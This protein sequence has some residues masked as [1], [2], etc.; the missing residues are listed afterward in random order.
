MGIY[1]QDFY[2]HNKLE[3]SKWIILLLVFG[4]CLKI[5]G[6]NT[7]QSKLVSIPPTPQASSL[8]KFLE[9]PVSENTGIPNITVPLYSIEFKNCSFP[10]TLKYHSSGLKVE[11]QSGNIGLG[12]ALEAGGTISSTVYDLPDF[13]V[14]S[15]YGTFPQNR[16]MNPQK[17][18]TG[19]GVYEE[20]ADYTQMMSLMGNPINHGASTSQG[21]KSDLQPDIFYYS[22]FDR[23]GKF[24]F[25]QNGTARPMPHNGLLIEKTS[26]GYRIK[27]EKG[28]VYLYEEPENIY[29]SST[30]YSNHQE[31]G[32]GSTSSL[33]VSYHL[34]NITTPLNEVINISYIT[35]NYSYANVP[36]YTRYRTLPGQQNCVGIEGE[37]RTETTTQITGKFINEITSNKGHRIKFVYSDCQRLDMPGTYALKQLEVYI[38]GV[39]NTIELIHGYFGLDSYDCNTQI[40]PLSVRLQLKKIKEQPK[41]DYSFDYFGG[42][43]GFPNRFSTQSD[44]WGYYNGTGSTFP[45]DQEFGFTIGGDKSPSL[46]NTRK[47]ILEKITYPTGGTT[48]FEH[49]LNQYLDTVATGTSTVQNGSG[50]YFEEYSPQPVSRT[51]NFTIPLNVNPNSIYVTYNC[52]DGTYDPQFSVLLHNGNNQYS[53]AFS[54]TGSTPEY[55]TLSPGNYAI[56]LYQSG[57]FEEGN[58]RIFWTETVGANPVVMN[59]NAGGLR[60]KTI[61]DYDALSIQPAHI[62]RY[63]YNQSANAAYSSGKV[64]NKPLYRYIYN[65]HSYT[66]NSDNT[67]LL[68]ETTCSYYLQTSKS[69]LPLTGLQ[70]NNTIYTE[71]QKYTEGPDNN[72]YT[73]NTYSFAYDLKPYNGYPFTPPTSYE[74]MSGYLLKSETFKKIPGSYC[75]IKRL[76]N[77]YNF[78]YTPPDIYQNYQ[79]SGAHYTLPIKP[80]EY[81]ALGLNIIVDRP[82]YVLNSAGGSRVYPARFIIQSFKLISSWVY[83]QN[84]TEELFE[85]C[86]SPILNSTLN[87]YDN[88]I[89]A[90]LSRT[91][92][93]SSNG[94][95]S[96]K[97]FTYAHDYPSVGNFIDDMKANNLVTLPI[98]RVSYEINAENQFSILSGE[99]VEYKLGGKGLIDNLYSL[100]TDKKINLPDFK[101]SNAP[102][103][104]LPSVSNPAS[105]LKDS[106]YVHKTNIFRYDDKGNVLQLSANAFPHRSYLY[107]YNKHYPVA[108]IKNADYA[109]I[110]GIL[111]VSAIENFG[112][113]LNPDKAAVDAF[114]APLKANLPNAFITSY[115]YKPLVGMT[116]QTDAKGMTTYY[117]YDAFGRLQYV[118]D[119]NQNIVKSNNYHYK[120]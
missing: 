76:T 113:Q 19:T 37:S 93:T 51:V 72:G 20:N 27:D 56:D 15:P 31:M 12:W 106:R 28:V 3:I 105:F 101:F 6:Q 83:L 16:E 74:W 67:S 41:G 18:L 114:L 107:S 80:N 34:T 47:G 102:N 58:F 4:N 69:K 63:T 38:N 64:F 98:E 118:K 55:I 84:N 11:E 7:P 87:Y 104:T 66:I 92:S 103:G 78:N 5:F 36:S 50:I 8:F 62:S 10:I 1:K 100:E 112:N 23:A 94:N 75:L 54:G 85:N 65:K 13:G 68:D 71:V 33:S 61:K 91:V 53:R 82:E 21:Q 2:R 57:N 25:T 35:Q 73:N 9:V 88:P 60:I 43:A 97:I 115:T 32:S 29:T 99:I 90:Q 40:D 110:E 70:F 48:V 119:Q 59:V 117:E 39:S 96:G 79:E 46:E 109:T 24:F 52:T 45:A 26:T 22:M 77:N 81:H 86:S 116:S 17:I 49:E 14:N 30:N 95:S 44:H 108:E 111:G 89:H 42:N 120:N